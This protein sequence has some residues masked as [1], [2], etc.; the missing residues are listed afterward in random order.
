MCPWQGPDLPSQIGEDWGCVVLP[1]LHPPGHSFVVLSMGGG[2]QE[3]AAWGEAPRQP[4]GADEMQRSWWMCWCITRQRRRQDKRWRWRNSRGNRTTSWQTRGVVV[5]QQWRC[6]NRLAKKR[7]TRGKR[8]GRRHQWS[9]KRTRGGSG[10][11]R[12]VTANSWKVSG[13]QCDN[14]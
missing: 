14:N 9:I 13:K 6:D 5:Q 2:P 8:E 7:Q 12:D 10:T 11:T 3:V 1:S 4:A